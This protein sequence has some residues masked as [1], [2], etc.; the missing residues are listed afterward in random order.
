MRKSEII[1]VK[2]KRLHSNY[3]QFDNIHCQ[4]ISNALDTKIQGPFALN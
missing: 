3:L 2:D 4:I 1:Y